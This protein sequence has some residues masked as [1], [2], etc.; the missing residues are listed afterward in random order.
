MHI[1]YDD[2]VCI[3]KKG[4]RVEQTAVSSY[5]DSVP[6]S[7]LCLGGGFVVLNLSGKSEHSE[8]VLFFGLL[9]DLINKLSSRAQIYDPFLILPAS[10]L[11]DKETDERLSASCWKLEGNVRF[12]ESRLCIAP[13]NLSLVGQ[14][15]RDLAA[16]K[17]PQELVRTV[18]DRALRLSFLECH[19][20]HLSGLNALRHCRSGRAIFR[21]L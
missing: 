10:P 5:R 1:V 3:V 16:R 6:A 15:V 18:R 4:F 8:P 12:C 2:Y 17:V 20:S 13:H 9:D 11:R 19:R 7:I 14:H 21:S